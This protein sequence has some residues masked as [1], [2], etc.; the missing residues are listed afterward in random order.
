MQGFWQGGR[1]QCRPGAC[2]VGDPYGSG[3]WPGLV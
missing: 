2:R 3:V 1:G